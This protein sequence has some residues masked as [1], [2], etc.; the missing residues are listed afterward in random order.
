VYPNPRNPHT[1][2]FV[3]LSPCRL[4]GVDNMTV[5]I[6]SDSHEKVKRIS[7]ISKKFFESANGMCGWRIPRISVI[8]ISGI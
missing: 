8:R 4:R 7:A 1:K 5:F 3:V 2:A 6:I